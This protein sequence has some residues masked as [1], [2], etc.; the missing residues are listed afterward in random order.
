MASNSWQVALAD[1][2]VSVCKFVTLPQA[3][4]QV[5]NSLMELNMISTEEQAPLSANLEIASLT[6]PGI[7]EAN[8]VA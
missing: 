1:G 6:S 7:F 2:V 3:G 4:V 5:G 8:E